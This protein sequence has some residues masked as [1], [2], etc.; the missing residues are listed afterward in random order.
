M[1][2]KVFAGTVVL[3][4]RIIE[5]GYVLVSDGKVQ[6]VGSGQPPVG[7]KHGGARYLVMPGA[8]DA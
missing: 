8:I 3:P 4:D 1:T 6:V 2:D 7:E 5:Q